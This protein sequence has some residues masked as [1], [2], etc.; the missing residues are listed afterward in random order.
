MIPTGLMNG[1]LTFADGESLTVSFIEMSPTMISFRLPLDYRG[2]T[3]AVILLSVDWYDRDTDTVCTVELPADSR[4]IAAI[5]EDELCLCVRLTIDD[6]AYAAAARQVSQD[7]LTYIRRRLTLDDIDLAAAYGAFDSGPAVWPASRREA[8]LQLA[9]KAGGRPKGFERLGTVPYGVMLISD[10]DRVVFLRE[11]EAAF[12][13]YYWQSRSLPDHPLASCPITAVVFGSGF[14]PHRE[15]TA[16]DWQTLTGRASELGLRAYLAIAP[17][18]EGLRSE[19]E[20]KL[21]AL[22]GTAAAGRDLTIL[23]GDWGMTGWLEA[24]GILSTTP[25]ILQNKRIKDPRRGGCLDTCLLPDGTYL[26]FGPLYQTNTGTFCPLAAAVGTGDRGRSWRRHSC[27]APCRRGAFLYPVSLSLIG[28]G[29]SLFGY[30]RTILSEGTV[31][32]S[33]SAAGTVIVNLPPV[34]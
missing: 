11:K 28:L 27:E 2:R 19:E 20:T 26:T 8:L 14:C 6:A 10:E 22:A 12:R 16:A 21:S 25:G 9:Q 4:K 3:E 5:D 31:F 32:A 34:S 1:R 15:G 13:A 7:Y 18:G 30:D 33:A 23:T 29:N 17:V 24:S